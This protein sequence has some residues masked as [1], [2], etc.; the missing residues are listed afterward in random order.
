[1]TRP[2][3]GPGRLLERIG[4]DAPRGMIAHDR[5]RLTGRLRPFRTLRSPS[6]VGPRDPWRGLRRVRLGGSRILATMRLG[7]RW[8]TTE[9][10][11]TPARP[12]SNPPVAPRG[13]WRERPMT[14]SALGTGRR[15]GSRVSATMRLEQRWL[16]TGPGWRA[17]SAPFGHPVA[18]SA[19]A[20]GDPGAAG[21]RSPR[22]PHPGIPIGWGRGP[23]GTPRTVFCRAHP[24][25]ARHTAI[26]PPPR[27][28]GHLA[29]AAAIVPCVAA[30]QRRD[31]VRRNDRRHG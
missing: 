18:T 30:H 21:I 28:P 8:P 5:T 17:G 3:S 31:P 13:S 9:P 27:L 16:T 24:A 19:L 29:P 22:S 14:R 1:M 6:G 12:L 7:E 11:D 10:A 15:G 20:V 4:D 2:A 23:S 26:G 25:S